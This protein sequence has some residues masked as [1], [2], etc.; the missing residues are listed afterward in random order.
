VTFNHAWS[1]PDD[2]IIIV[3]A[4]DEY[5]GESSQSSFK[6]KISKN[7]ASINPVLFHLLENLMN[8]RYSIIKLA[9][10]LIKI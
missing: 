10:A 8:R 2:Y 3:R 1:E 7:R 9:I 4:K 6:L 5:E